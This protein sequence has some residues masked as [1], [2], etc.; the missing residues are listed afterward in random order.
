MSIDRRGAL[1]LIGAA[2][3]ATLAGP[4]AAQAAGRVVIVGAGFGGAACAR[5]L[6]RIAP[7]I[8]VTVIER[9]EAIVTCP[10]SNLV[11]GGLRDIGAITHGL[12]GLRAAGVEVIRDTVTGIDP[13]ARTVTLA[14]GPTLTYDRLVL[15]PGVDLNWG[16]IPGYDAAAAEI[17]PHA[18][19]AGPQTLLLRD[20]LLAMDDGG[21]VIIAPPLDPSRCPPGPYERASLIA[22][23][24][25]TSKPRSKILI[26][27]AKDSFSKQGLFQQAW[28][29]LYPGLIEWVPFSQTG[30]ILAVDPATRS[31]ETAFETFTGAVVNIIPPQRAGAVA[32]DAGLTGGADW[33]E[34]DPVAFESRVAPGVHV[35]GDAAI[36]GDMPKS[37]FSAAMQGM[38][39][40]AALAAL[41]AGQAPEPGVLMNTCYSLAGPDYGIS[42][43][44]VYRPV[45]GALRGVEGAGGLSPLDSGPEARVAEARHGEGWYAAITALLW[46]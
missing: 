34:V 2:A 25:Q 20:Q 44:G 39:C 33:C 7:G 5:A 23:Y 35:L 45:D 18:W 38:Q 9:E 8:S 11:L 46:G 26:V 31:I 4:A 28:E 42:V 29:T 43:A 15:S 36:M 16:A 32:R 24:L 10:F 12:D 40:A 6:A 17:L 3:A 19:K 41:Q 37:G 14:A 27:D 13:G 1:G 22:H 21:T 30:G